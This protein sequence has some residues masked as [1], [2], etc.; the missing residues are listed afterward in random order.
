MGYGLR[1]PKSLRIV[2]GVLGGFF[3][4]SG[5]N[6]IFDPTA[7]AEVLGVAL[8]TGLARSTLIGDLGS[9]FL[10][11]GTLVLLGAITAQAHWLQA[12]SLLFG[13]AAIMRTLA[14]AMH[15]ADF[16][17]VFILAEIVSTALLLFAASRAS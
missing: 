12:A 10:T 9:F 16:A 3:L 6:W 8:P 15:G 7:A 13:G 4:L 5:L 17:E 1:M 2:V 11:A 14:W